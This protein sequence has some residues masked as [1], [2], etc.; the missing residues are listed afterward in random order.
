MKAFLIVAFL[1]VAIGQLVFFL[2]VFRTLRN[3]SRSSALASTRLM[4]ILGGGFFFLF[5]IGFAIYSLFLT[6]T[7]VRT[8]GEVIGY[9]ESHDKDGAM[10]SPVFAFT[11]QLGERFQ[12]TA[13]MSSRPRQFHVGAII[14]VLYRSS[15]PYSARPDTFSYNWLFPL[16][17]GGGGALMFCIGVTLPFWRRLLRL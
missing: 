17:F 9:E 11:N 13:P 5:G 1:I 3:R 15:D 12:V 4:F 8:K 2:F 14:P 10:Y 7:G 16:A 6:T